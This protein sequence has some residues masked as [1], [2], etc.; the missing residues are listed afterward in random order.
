LLQLDAIRARH[1]K[2]RVEFYADRKSAS[3]ILG[4]S[5]CNHRKQVAALIA[6]P[7]IG[8]LIS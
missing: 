5:V 6:A 7:A 8:C 3:S 4:G 1:R 2:C